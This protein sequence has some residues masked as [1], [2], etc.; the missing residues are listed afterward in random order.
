[1]DRIQQDRRHGE[2]YH[3]FIGT[4]QN[5][6]LC[7]DRQSVG[8]HARLWVGMERWLLLWSRPNVTTPLLSHHPSHDAII[9]TFPIGK[10]E[11]GVEER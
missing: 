9:Q 10:R 8:A 1:M 7:H 4:I 6:I 5:D 2:R 11:R 3:I